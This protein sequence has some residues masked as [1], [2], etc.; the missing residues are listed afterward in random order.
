MIDIYFHDQTI[1]SDLNVLKIDSQLHTKLAALNSVFTE[2]T[3]VYRNE[4]NRKQNWIY[5]T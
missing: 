5:V 2:V 4:K 1:G 3:F